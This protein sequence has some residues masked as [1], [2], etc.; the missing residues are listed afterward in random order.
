MPLTDVFCR[1]VKPAEKARKYFDAHGLFLYV[2]PQGGKLWRLKFRLQGKERLLALGKY[3]DVSLK[4]ARELR[5]EARELI[6][7]GVD[8]LQHRKEIERERKEAEQARTVTF[9]KVA[10]EWLQLKQG[11]VKP[12]T[13]TQTAKR[14]ETHVL[15]YLANVPLATLEPADVLKPLREVEK[16][17]KYDTAHK[18]LTDIS[19]VCRYAR[20]AGLCKFNPAADLTDALK[21]VP[22]TVHRAAYTDPKDIA[23]FMQTLETCR[24]GPAVRFCLQLLPY[25]CL[26]ISEL[27]GCRWKEVDLERAVLTIPASRMKM[28][29]EHTVPLPRQAVALF[30]T[31]KQF[32]GTSPRCFPMDGNKSKSVTRQG[33]LSAL[34]RI[35]IEQQEMCLHGTRI[36]FSTVCN[37]WKWAKSDWIEAQLAHED[38]NAVRATY[39]HQNY[40][41]ERRELMQAWAD[42]LDELKADP[43]QAEAIAAKYAAGPNL[44][45]NPTGSQTG[46]A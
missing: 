13:F 11:T 46:K 26:R 1:S 17:G 40:L 16:A 29:K 12:V 8:P 3:P 21:P 6:A 2:T 34:R 30:Q 19:A 22:K 27:A 28:G 43:E 41:A 23:Y 25:V 35:G 14:L 15:P 31:L 33:L 7:Q 45:E 24:S 20:A 36:M 5:D 9:G 32:T 10:A 38:E 42:F 44:S 4:R 39:N 37:G 18:L